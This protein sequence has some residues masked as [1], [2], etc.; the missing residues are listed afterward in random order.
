MAKY[1]GIFLFGVFISSVAQVLLKKS[2]MKGHRTVW[3]EYLNPLVIGAYFLLAVAAILSVVAYRGIPLSMGPVLEA[4]GY[5]Y[6]A[7]F[8]ARVFKEKISRQRAAALGLVIAG[9]FV[10]SF[11]G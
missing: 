5:L 8:G 9:I 1:A 11:W 2:A 6:V 7:Y 4:S 10:Y 3:Q